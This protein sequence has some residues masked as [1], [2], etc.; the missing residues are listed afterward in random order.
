LTMA[1]ATGVSS[2]SSAHPL[3][4][5]LSGIPQDATH[6]AFDE[7]AH[8]IIVFNHVGKEVGRVKPGNGTQGLSRRDTPGPCGTLSSDDV[9][10]RRFSSLCNILFLTS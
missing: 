9:Q 5:H 3:P 6:L 8:V 7:D 4:T 1:I 2:R 10:K